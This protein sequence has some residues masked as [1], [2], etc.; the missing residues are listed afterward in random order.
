M[1]ALIAPFDL[2]VDKLA[3][4]V[5]LGDCSTSGRG[6]VRRE[7]TPSLDANKCHFDAPIDNSISATLYN[8]AL[9]YAWFL[10]LDFGTVDLDTQFSPPPFPSS[11][12]SPPVEPSQKYH[13]R[14]RGLREELIF[15]VAHPGPF[16]GWFLAYILQ[17]VHRRTSLKFTKSYVK[18]DKFNS[19]QV[20]L[21]TNQCLCNVITLDHITISPSPR[22]IEFFEFGNDRI[23]FHSAVLFESGLVEFWEF[24]SKWVCFFS[25][26]CFLFFQS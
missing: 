17:K 1:G 21:W 26:L 22:Q 19:I 6:P 18:N 15:A 23:W 16:I 11:L 8:R 9:V 10:I 3:A 13:D 20:F 24:L 14:P 5:H 7:G 25:L 4:F 12:Q 2:L